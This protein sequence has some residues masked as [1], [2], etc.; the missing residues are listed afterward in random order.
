MSS[1]NNIDKNFNASFLLVIYYNYYYNNQK[2][3]ININ[4]IDKYI[5]DTIISLND[6]LY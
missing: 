3:N 1:D 4:K 5:S 6:N 2:Q